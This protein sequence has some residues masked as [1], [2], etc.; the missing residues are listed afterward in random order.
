MTEGKNINDAMDM[1]ADYIGTISLDTKKMPKS[2]Y[3]LPKAGKNEI[4]TLIKVNLSR[5]RRE[6]DDRAIKKL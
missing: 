4:V 2:N 6:N 5:Y 3:S 1:A